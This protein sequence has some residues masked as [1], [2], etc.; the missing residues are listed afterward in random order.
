MEAGD[1]LAQ[2][3]VVVAVDRGTRLFAAL[4]PGLEVFSGS[5][6]DI[7]TVGSP[8]TEGLY[9]GGEPEKQIRLEDR[10][11]D[12]GLAPSG[13][14]ALERGV[15][16]AGISGC[17]CCCEVNELPYPFCS[18]CFSPATCAGPPAPLAR[19]LSACPSGR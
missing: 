1:V 5:V 10:F 8:A 3:L 16:A 13:T 7:D 12:F 6:G 14:Q 15:E 4:D 18:S 9:R 11:L 2:A 19:L 17:L